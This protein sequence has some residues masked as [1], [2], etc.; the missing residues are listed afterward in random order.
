LLDRPW[1]E[2]W[3]TRLEEELEALSQHSCEFDIDDA[4]R[5]R[6]I[7]KLRV[8]T[9]GDHPAG[10]H[11]LTALYPDEFPFFRPEV[12]AF[13]LD[14]PRHQNPFDHNLCLLGRAT[15]NWDPE[16]TLADL[17]YEQLPKVIERGPIVD[18][19]VLEGD[20]GEQA[21]PR[22][23]YYEYEPGS[24]VLWD[25]AHAVPPSV[26]R[27]K[28]VIA[29]PQGGLAFWG[30][31]V[32]VR[33]ERGT[34]FFDSEPV[35]AGRFPGRSGFRWIRTPPPPRKT[36]QETQAWL[37]ERYP[38][39]LEEMNRGVRWSNRYCNVAAI[40]YEEELAP[41]RHGDAWLFLVHEHDGAGRG[42]L[43]LARPAS[44]SEALM[45][46]RVPELSFLRDASIAL[47]GAGCIGAPIALEV[48]RAGAARLSVIDP[49]VVEA[50]TTVRWPLGVAAV[51]Q[52]KVGVLKSL[53]DNSYPFT[54]FR[55][56]PWRIGQVY[57]GA[58]SPDLRSARELTG[59]WLQDADVIADTTAEWGVHFYL[60]ELARSR[61]IPYVGVSGTPGGWGGTMYRVSAEAGPCWGCI[62]RWQKD[63]A[64]PVPAAAPDQEGL[65]QPRGCADPTFTGAGFDLGHVA[66]AGAR[67]LVM[68]LA[69]HMGGTYPDVPWNYAAV[70]LRAES[71]EAMAPRWETADA[72]V[73]PDCERCRR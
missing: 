43:Y 35:P 54:D 56:Y 2:H 13:H 36:A 51:G 33:D 68:T 72:E 48:A 30:A 4:A 1:Y 46:E 21:E 27:G 14:L 8:R 25:P 9:P 50:G 38:W 59:E 64:L 42:R 57:E 19:E 5:M 69:S 37:L 67:L 63:G 3:P 73:H 60:S 18:P 41:G 26:A 53:I 61:S 55:P 34:V 62:A 20:P 70:S 6:G 16:S 45:F 10:R 24:F 44:Y 49:D 31:V 58:P 66:L 40:L 11:D 15:V 22:S 47:A 39:V 23:T 29:H 7:L 28:L 52:H 32:R 65:F 12:Y 17:L 71:G